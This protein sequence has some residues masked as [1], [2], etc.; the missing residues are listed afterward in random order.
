M[1]FGVWLTE[2]R[3]SRT[4]SQGEVAAHLGVGIKTYSSWEQD[5]VEQFSA[6][7]LAQIAE[8]FGE[9][10]EYVCRIWFRTYRGGQPNA[11]VSVKKEG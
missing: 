1:P 8:F 3:L 6:K 11:N 7:R 10:G 4:M 5:R 9:P 2:K